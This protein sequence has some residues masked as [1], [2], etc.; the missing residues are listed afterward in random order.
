MSTGK[1][2]HCGYSPV[3]QDATWCPKCEGTYPNPSRTSSCINRLLVI[4]VVAFFL[5]FGLIVIGLIMSV[6]G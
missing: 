3:G 2:R 6:M 5:F 1:C 4:M